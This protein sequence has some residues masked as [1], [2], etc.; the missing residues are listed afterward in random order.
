MLCEIIEHDQF[1]V[2]LI[3]SANISLSDISIL[4]YILSNMKTLYLKTMMQKN[5]LRAIYNWCNDIVCPVECAS[6]GDKTAG[7]RECNSF[8]TNG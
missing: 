6:T 4:V 3:L 8:L 2:R 5:M 7:V 1:M